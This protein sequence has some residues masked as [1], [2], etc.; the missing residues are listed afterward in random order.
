MTALHLPA[1]AALL[2]AAT[3]GLLGAPGAAFAQQPMSVP[4]PAPAPVPVPVPGVDTSVH[5]G[6]DFF[7]FANGEWL[8]ATEIPAGRARWRV[9]DEMQALARQQVARLLDDAVDIPG[10]DEEGARENLRGACELGEEQRSPPTAREPR[11]RLAEHELLCHEVH[12]VAQRRDHHHVGTAVERDE[13]GLGDV[14]MH[15]LDRRDAL[16]R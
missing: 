6:D 12:P 9:R 15:V 5:P 4:V 8:K 16:S 1:A 7:A 10:V 11:L 3:M 14:A 2:L 13:R